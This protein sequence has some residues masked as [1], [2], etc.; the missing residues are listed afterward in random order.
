MK[1]R[2]QITK[3]RSIRFL[4]HLEY[5][6][7]VERAIRR[8]KLPAAYSEGFNQRMKFSLA[9]ALSVGVA[10]YAEYVEIEL[11]EPMEPRA[12]MQALA[13]SLPAG[14]RVLAADAVENS[15]P[16]LMA[17]AAGASYRV[18]LPGEIALEKAVA[19]FNAAVSLPFNKIAPKR[20]EKTKEIDVKA[21][22]S[23]L[24]ARQE[25]GRTEL[26][27]DCKITQS[28]SMK[29]VDLLKALNQYYGLELP[30]AQADIE[31]LRLYRTDAAGQKLPLLADNA[32]A[33]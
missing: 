29:A 12:A 17:Q 31:R 13:R 21:Y 27:F 19:A 22:I 6:R 18:T 3:E 28:G 26:L 24:T 10:S 1:L 20:Q 25:D 4:S 8:A 30:V 23:F 33:M 9:S 32:C 16:A 11:A 14:I 5:L 2:L 15:R 7:T